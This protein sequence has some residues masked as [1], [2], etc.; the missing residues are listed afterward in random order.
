[1]PEVQ[2][3]PSFLVFFRGS[4]VDSSTVMLGVQRWPSFLVFF[5]LNSL[6]ALLPS[7]LSA[8]P[9]HVLFIPDAL[10]YPLQGSGFCTQIV[11]WD[12]KKALNLRSM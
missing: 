11:Y 5:P 3:W 9:N 1:M 8:S 2:R 4:L 6:A 10:L 12:I 7:S